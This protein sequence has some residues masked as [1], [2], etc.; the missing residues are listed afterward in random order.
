MTGV[1]RF[2]LLTTLLLVGACNKAS[3][4]PEYELTGSTM[5]TTYSIKLVAPAESVSKDALRQQ[6]G[7]TLEQV[8]QLAS[9]Y[10]DLSELSAFNAN[11]STDWITVTAELCGA[12][13]QALDV[14]RRTD[15][16]FDLTVGPLV[17]LWGFGV[18]GAAVQPPAQAEIDSAL[19]RVGYKRLQTSCS[20]PAIRKDSHDIYVDLSGWAKGYAVDRLA[21]L[22]DE[23]AL[24]DYLVEIGGELR[25][26]G[27]NADRLLWAVAIERPEDS[28]RAPQTIVRL[29][30]R[31]LA[32]SGDYRNYFEYEGR[33]YSHTID[34][35]SGWPVSH[36]LAA[37]TVIDQSAAFADAMATALLVLGPE[38]GPALAEKLGIAGYF[39][40][41]GQTGIE[42]LTTSFFDKIVKQ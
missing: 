12:I 16:A 35:R 24:T 31:G 37:V 42:E 20:V 14:S 39:L 5:G 13:E 41:H 2:A 25:V 10:R 18:N 32:T 22:L 7:D 19:S 3:R 38:G 26:R 9:T 28:M 23:N 15:G 6:I 30:D 36:A 8:E 29:T 21:T 11:R 4:L 40:V 33:R 1:F 27:H 17:N 34:A